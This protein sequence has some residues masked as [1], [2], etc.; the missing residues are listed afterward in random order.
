MNRKEIDKAEREDVS[1]D[2][3]ENALK[4]VLLAPRGDARSEN[5]EPTKKELETRWKMTRRKSNG[6]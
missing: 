2:D 3:F 5:R 1:R 4:S 6:T